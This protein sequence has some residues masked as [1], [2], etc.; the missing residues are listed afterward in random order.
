MQAPGPGSGHRRR[1][2]KAR[3]GSSSPFRRRPCALLV[4]RQAGGLPYD[5]EGAAL[6]GRI[7]PDLE[8]LEGVAL[9]D[10]RVAAD[11]Q[12]HGLDE[13]LVQSRVGAVAQA[14]PGLVAAAAARAEREADCACVSDV[15]DRRLDRLA[16]VL[17]AGIGHPL[18]FAE[19][20]PGADELV[21]ERQDVLLGRL[22][23]QLRRQAVDFLGL[24]VT[25]GVD[26]VVGLVLGARVGRLVLVVAIAGLR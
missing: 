12:F 24:V 21:R 1:R 14:A 3:S 17:G 20:A 13:I 2:K 25:V 15:G 9:E 4:G 23:A 6:A 19:T 7:R 18:A 26:A 5:D 11:L 22:H 8:I 10:P 16:P